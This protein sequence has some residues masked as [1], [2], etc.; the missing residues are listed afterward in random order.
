MNAFAKSKELIV[1]ASKNIF[2]SSG[3][4]RKERSVLRELTTSR[5]LEKTK[6]FVIISSD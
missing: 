5:L 1:A 2:V 3:L 6:F 4:A